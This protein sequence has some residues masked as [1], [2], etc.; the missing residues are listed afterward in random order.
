MI[1]LHTHILPQVDDG[2]TSLE[3]SM[4]MAQDALKAGIAHLVATP[5]IL[6]YPDKEYLLLV[7]RQFGLLQEC[8]S[9]SIPLKITLAAEIFIMP[10]LDRLLQE[11]PALA[12]AQR[13]V[14]IELPRFDLPSFTRPVLLRLLEQGWQPLIAHPERCL[15]LGEALGFAQ[16]LKERGILFQVNAPSLLGKYGPEIKKTAQ[17][18]LKRGLISIMASDIHGPIQKGLSKKNLV[19]RY[20]SRHKQHPLVHAREEAAKLISPSAVQDLIQG[21]PA[22]I[23]FFPHST[24]RKT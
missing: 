5:H 3:E 7:K 20:L 9:K 18:M 16:E 23:L 21:Q 11:H 8:I 13:T 1:D 24:N 6:D 22:R 10:D 17:E 2:A 14:L 4:T 15:P 12:I 19:A